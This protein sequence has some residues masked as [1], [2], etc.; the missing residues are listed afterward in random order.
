MKC[1]DNV[2]DSN[3]NVMLD[4]NDIDVLAN[5]PLKVYFFSTTDICRIILDII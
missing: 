3:D 4:N 5:E 1:N 2:L